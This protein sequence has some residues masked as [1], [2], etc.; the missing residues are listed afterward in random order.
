MYILTGQTV[1]VVNGPLEIM[2]LGIFNC[3]KIQVLV[4]DCSRKIDYFYL[5]YG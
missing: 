4:K 1:G 2:G 5:L 3:L